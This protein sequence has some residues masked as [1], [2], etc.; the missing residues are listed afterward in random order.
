MMR[1]IFLILQ[2]ELNE[3][4]RDKRTWMV[5]V[6][7]SLIFPIYMFGVMEF[8]MKRSSDPKPVEYWVEGAEQAPALI[9]Y[10]TENGFDRAADEDSAMVHMNIPDD[11]AEKIAT[12]YIPIITLRADLTDEPK[13]VRDFRSSVQA[14]AQEI[15]VSRLVTRG[16]SPILLNPYQVD[17][18][19]TAE[20]G[21]MLARYFAPILIVM[22]F[23][24]PMSALVPAAIDTTA[25]ERERNGL[26]PLLLQPISAWNLAA[27]KLLMMTIL[28]LIS[29]TLVI[30]M[31][32]VVLNFLD[33][34]GL[35]FSLDTGLRSSVLIVLTLL[36]AIMLASV[37]LLGVASFGKSF[38]EG[39]TYVM[40]GMF[41]P[42]LFVGAGFALDGL[43]R[44][45][46]PFWSEIT[47]LTSV[48]GG[49]SV[50]WWPWIANVFGYV[51]FIT[52]FLF[53]I[54]R[55]FKRNALKG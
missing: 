51:I 30:V 50:L 31:S 52:M 36:P 44:V 20:H 40:I 11:F 7:M 22:F 28:G 27:G 21:S 47:V 12:G 8:S 14:Y 35:K 3:V 15:A 43:W 42:M 25:G 9:S 18:Q 54:G 45:H 29:M 32:G 41:V 10:L 48:V 1:N 39:Q 23:M 37:I 5:L 55:G 13:S 17:I 6:S 53:L 4:R 26:F 19:D 16:V 34:G 2:K 49:Q 38:K 24:V 46:L 33:L